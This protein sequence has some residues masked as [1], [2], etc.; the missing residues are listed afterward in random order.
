MN[1]Q[2]AVLMFKKKGSKRSP[3]INTNYQVTYKKLNIRMVLDQ[4]LSLHQYL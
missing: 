1:I 4:I 2:W 3:Q